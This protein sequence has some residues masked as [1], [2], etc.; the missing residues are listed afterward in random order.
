MATD[1]KYRNS[2]SFG[3]R[4]N[5]AVVAGRSAA[6]VARV[7]RLGTGSMI[8]GRVALML[9]PH[10]LNKLTTDRHVVLV[11]ATNGKTTT[12]RMVTAA[13]ATLGDVVSNSLGANMTSGHVTAL[14]GSSPT[15]SAVLEV[16]ER[17]LPEVLDATHA[18]VVALLNLSHDQLDRTHEVSA[19]AIA[20][21]EALK[22]TPPDH[23]IANADD[24]LVTWA[25]KAVDNVHWVSPANITGDVLGCPACNSLIEYSADD[26]HCTG[27]DLKR[28]QPELWLDDSTIY[29]TSTSGTPEPLSTLDLRLPGK[30]NEINATMATAAAR[31]LGVE[32][33]RAVAAFKSLTDVAG[34]YRIVDYAGS[35]LRL[36]LAKNPAGWRQALDMLEPAPRPVIISINAQTG[37]GKDT[38]WLWDVPFEELRERKVIALGE[39]R[40]DLAVRLKYA[41][42]EHVVARSLDEAVRLL[43]E[44]EIDL[45]ANY[46]AFQIH[47]KEVSGAP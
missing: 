18:D 11:S 5:A 45:V 23:V 6:A 10:L 17:W 8:G 3:I 35:Q 13:L 27:C 22:K 7:A 2:G 40:S 12:T 28:P 14:L 44:P 24:P 47:L 19:H 21:R 29:A 4:G 25:A 37:D 16:D 26:W 1:T 32:P 33:S 30:V 42:V 15:T 43:G 9:D 36:L 20:W 46:T 38:S 41:E 34:R 39:R 31:A